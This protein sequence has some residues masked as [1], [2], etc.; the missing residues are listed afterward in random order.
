M[1]VCK[2][3]PDINECLDC[4]D[5]Q[6]TYGI[7]YDCERCSKRDN[8]YYEIIREV[9]TFF[10][11]KYVVILKDDAEVKVKMDRIYDVKE[12]LNVF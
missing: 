4:L 1:K 10:G 7:H 9:K 2:L 12:I 3:K 5:Y 8:T 11:K 6:I